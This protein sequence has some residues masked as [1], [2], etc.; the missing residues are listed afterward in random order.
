MA[1]NIAAGPPS[2]PVS[3]LKDCSEVTKFK[4]S[5][6]NTAVALMTYLMK[7]GPAAGFP[8]TA[9]FCLATQAIAMSS[10]GMNQLVEVNFDRLMNRTRN[11]PL[12]T[13]RISK[14]TAALLAASLYGT[15]NL[16]FAT[17]F[18]WNSVLVANTILWSYIG[19]YTPLKRLSKVNTT[20]GAVVGALPPFL[21]W[22]AAGGLLT[23][24]EPLAVAMYMF[25]WQFPHFYGIL[26][27][28]KRDYAN[29][30]FQML[31]D[32]KVAGR[33]IRVAAVLKLISVGLLTMTSHLHPVS[34]AVMVP[35]TYKYNWVP[36]SKFIADPTPQNA[37]SMKINS[38]IPWMVFFCL[39]YGKT[40][41]TIIK[42]KLAAAEDTQE[43]VA[44]VA[45]PVD[46]SNNDTAGTTSK[47][48]STA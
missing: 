33:N 32:H 23:D 17:C 6:M 11:R 24:L 14:Q 25:A 12:P 39:L 37:R 47:P 48:I 15:S 31:D 40:I 44:A 34:A 22:A 21:G 35:L 20:L 41:Y 1:P 19:M 3:L 45:A 9:L 10:Q 4:L 8:D 26:W 18:N 43:T 16:I 13:N 38:Y 30:G 28:Y 7:A 5:A 36:A 46:K 29:A 2:S 42:G 27:M